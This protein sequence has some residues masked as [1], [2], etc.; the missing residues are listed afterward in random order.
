MNLDFSEEQQMLSDTAAGICGEY[1][2]IE[3]VRA[4]EDDSVGYTPEFWKQ[5]SGLGVLGLTIPDAYGGM[6]LSTLDAVVV[7]EQFGRTLAQSPHFVSAIL[8]AGVLKAA[9]SED[10]KTTWL[11]KVCS[12]EA[13]LVPAWLEPG[14]GCGAAGVQMKAVREGQE[15]RLSG[16]KRHV[17]FAGSATRFVVLARSEEDGDGIG[18]FLVDSATP[19]L[20]LTQQQTLAS[21]CQ[22]EV[23][24]EDVRIP[25]TDRIGEPGAGWQVWNDVMHE[26]IILLAAQAM[27]GAQRAMEITVQYSLDR[28]QFGKPLGAFQALAHNMADGQTTIDGGRTLAYEAAWALTDGKP[29]D[30]LAPMAKMFACQTFRDVTATCVQIHGGMGFTIEYDIQLFFRRAKQL[31]LSWWDTAYLEDLIATAV[32]EGH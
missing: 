29:V 7:Y 4:L 3:V 24:F 15:Y 19:G 18:L 23:S 2:T 12:G 10:Q 22:Y 26:G 13:V 25:V 27:G 14:N 9:G 28:H 8:S 5:L 20:T 21:D 32:L 17:A 31:Q 11:P 16:T 30:R 1:S 6:G